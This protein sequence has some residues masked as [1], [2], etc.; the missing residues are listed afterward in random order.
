MTSKEALTNLAQAVYRAISESDEV[1]AAINAY[2]EAELEVTS[3]RVK[4]DAVVR[5]LN[6]AAVEKSDA[7]FLRSLRI[8]SDLTPEG[9]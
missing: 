6:A 1:C 7:D 4:V 8:A 2:A 9:N 5:D 3:L